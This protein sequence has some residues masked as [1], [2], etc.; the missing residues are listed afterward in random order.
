MVNDQI[1]KLV[2]DEHI[3]SLL[4]TVALQQSKQHAHHHHYRDATFRVASLNAK[5]TKS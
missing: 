5:R 2:K 4:I 1:D 3:I